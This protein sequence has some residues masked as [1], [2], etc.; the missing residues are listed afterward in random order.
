MF[1]GPFHI[2]DPNKL[3][4]EGDFFRGGCCYCGRGAVE[5]VLKEC[6]HRGTVVKGGEE[7]KRDD[8]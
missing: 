6:V 1:D 4:S 8:R 5:A 7:V 2:P 3:A